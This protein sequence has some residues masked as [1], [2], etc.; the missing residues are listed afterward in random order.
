MSTSLLFASLWSTKMLFW[1]SPKANFLRNWLTY[2]H[3]HTTI[4]ACRHTHIH[5]RMHACTHTHAYTQTCAFLE[6]YMC[7]LCIFM[8]CGDPPTLALIVS[9]LYVR[10]FCVLT[11][12]RKSWDIIACVAVCSYMRRQRSA[13]RCPRERTTTRCYAVM[14]RPDLSCMLQWCYW[15]Y[16]KMYGLLLV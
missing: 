8:Q 12:A 4:L 6:M 13:S 10:Y 16:N 9:A 1:S 5:K 11:S 15:M 2:T 14:R 7:T 3:T